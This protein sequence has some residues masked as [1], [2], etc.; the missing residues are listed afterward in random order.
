MI[1]LTSRYEGL[2]KVLLEAIACEVPI[3]ASRVGGIP[4]IVK[5]KHNGYLI[6]SININKLKVKW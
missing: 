3:L 2:G 4:E 6:D 1:C 5:N